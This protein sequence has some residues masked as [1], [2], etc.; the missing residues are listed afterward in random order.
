MIPTKDKTNT[1]VIQQ[2]W[3]TVSQIAVAVALGVLT[4]S[5]TAFAADKPHGHAYTGDFHVP[6]LTLCVPID[7]LRRWRSAGVM[8]VS[9]TVAMIL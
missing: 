6:C 1:D 5:Q 2:G 4:V 9:G 8:A 7:G 3:M